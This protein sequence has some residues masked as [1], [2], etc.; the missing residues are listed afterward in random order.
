[1]K[2]FL[3][4]F[5]TTVFSPLI[6]IYLLK[7]RKKGKEDSG[8]R[9]SERLGISSAKR[10]K[11]KLVCFVCASVGESLS[12]LPLLDE[13]LKKNFNVLVL[14]TTTSSA[15]VLAKKLPKKVIHQYMPVDVNFWVKRFFKNWK[16]DFIFSVDSEIWP[17]FI[18]NAKKFGAVYSVLNARMT[19]KSF[20]AWEKR[21]S[22]AK[23]LFSNI[24]NVLAYDEKNAKRFKSLGVKNSKN[25]DN[26][27]YFFNPNLS[28]KSELEKLRKEIG[29]KQVYIVSSTHPNEEEKLFEAHKKI[30]KKNSD[31]LMILAPRHPNRSGDIQEILNGFNLKYAVRSKGDK[32]EKDTSVYLADTFGELFSFYSLYDIVFMGGS[33]VK[34]GGH[35]PI[36][37]AYFSCAVLS[38]KYVMNFEKVFDDMKKD[39]AVIFVKNSNE[40]ADEILR[41]FEDKNIL[42]KYKNNA[43]NFVDKKQVVA[44]NYLKEIFKIIA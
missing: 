16:P 19:D 12:I 34:W 7:R 6:Y 23:Q 43:K 1:M 22:F 3:Y 27:K 13:L 39:D 36:E 26:L 15:G 40:V 38:G 4:R 21:K 11:G 28:A 32:V 17:N 24:E 18:L 8:A 20:N 33:L 44:E 29:R 5:L 9:F 35:N 42:K 2:L 30:L 14:T 41:L 10:P 25:L 37:P 31:V